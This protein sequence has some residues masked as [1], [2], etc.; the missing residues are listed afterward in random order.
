MFQAEVL[1]IREA[2][3]YVRERNDLNI[4]YV[5]FFSDSQA[6]LKALNK[7]DVTSRIVWQ[8]HDIL[9]GLA[10]KIRRCTLVWIKA[11]VG[12]DVNVNE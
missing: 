3:I 7:K 2:A 5:K 12:H 10:S 11:H 4:K 1:A 6:A 9:N 8:T